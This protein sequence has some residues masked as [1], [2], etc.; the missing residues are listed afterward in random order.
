MRYLLDTHVL[1][2]AA[3]DTLPRSARKYFSEEHT[4]YFSS[5]SLWEIVIKRALNREDFQIDPR[6]FHTALIA[7]GYLELSITS[8][9]A[10]TLE[11]LP[12]IHKDPFDR[13]L[14]SQA[15]TEKMDLV[16]A[17]AYLSNYPN[18]IIMV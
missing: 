17:D 5:A 10:L 13:I 6:A 3:E 12:P 18:H 9:H 1:L 4:L 14:L 15:I 8:Q 7:A 11:S 2:W 16:T